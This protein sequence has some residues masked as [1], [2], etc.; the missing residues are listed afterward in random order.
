[1]SGQLPANRVAG[2]WSDERRQ[3]TSDGYWCLKKKDGRIPRGRQPR[4]RFVQINVGIKNLE[5][6]LRFGRAKRSKAGERQ[7]V[8]TKARLKLV[9]GGAVFCE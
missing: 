6:A 4:E 5:P 9:R 8:A 1:M 3:P 7:R 2:R